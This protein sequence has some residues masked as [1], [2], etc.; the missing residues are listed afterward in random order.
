MV[1]GEVSTIDTAPLELAFKLLAVKVL[2]PVKFM[3][4]DP[5]LRSPVGEV[6]T[7]L[8]RMPL[9][10][11]L[12]F[13]VNVVPALAF[14]VMTLLLVS[15][16]DTAPPVEFAVKLPAFNVLAPVKLIP[17]IPALRSALGALSVPLARMP[18]LPPVAFKVNDD[19]ELVCNVMGPL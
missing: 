18:L 8:P 12:A 13:S 4:P 10:G 7:P 3:P 11:S 1:T 17:A 15:I 14:N 16:I 9:A 6:R 5:A 2:P 19:P